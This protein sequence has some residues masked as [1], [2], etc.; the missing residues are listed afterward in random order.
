MWLQHF[1][2]LRSPNWKTNTCAK[3][4][5][6][7]ITYSLQSIFLLSF[8]PF[9][10]EDLVVQMQAGARK[11]ATGQAAGP[12]G[13]WLLYHSWANHFSSQTNW[14]LEMFNELVS[15]VS[16]LRLGN[17]ARLAPKSRS[18]FIT[19]SRSLDHKGWPLLCRASYN[20]FF[21]CPPDPEAD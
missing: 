7:T 21:H 12:H 18:Q 11:P 19:V 9:S 3:Q 5:E 17:T 15:L 6:R 10:S 1:I 16:C 14:K 4:R 8:S 2:Y 13:F 20:C